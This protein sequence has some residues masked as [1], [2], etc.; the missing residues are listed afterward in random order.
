[1]A[2][3][4]FGEHFPPSSGN[5]FVSVGD[6]LDASCRFGLPHFQRGH[7]WH[8]D[9]VSRL[10][11]SLMWDTPCGSIIL[12]QPEGPIDDF[13]EPVREWGTN[14]LEYLVVDGQ[15]R[16]TALRDA[17]RSPVP[18]AVNLAAVPQFRALADGQ[19]PRRLRSRPLFV[20][21]PAVPVRVAPAPEVSPARQRAY[22]A[23]VRD[24]VR[25]TA[26]DE[27]GTSAWPEHYAH[28]R[29][30]GVGENLWRRMVDGLRAIPN[31][32]MQVVVKQGTSLSEIVQLYN[33]INSSGVAVRAE[34]R[35]FAAMVG[36]EPGAAAWLRECFASAHGYSA[37][38]AAQVDHNALLKRERERRFGFPLFVRTYAQAA[39]HHMD[40]DTSDL[41]YIS[42]LAWED[43]W[44]RAPQARADILDDSRVAI[45]RVANVVGRRLGCD[46]FRFVPAAEPLRPAF[47]LVLKYPDVDDPT[48]AGAVLRLQLGPLGGGPTDPPTRTRDIRSSNTLGEAVSALPTLPSRE[49]LLAS[50]TAC[51]SMQS[52]W[53]SVLYW[54]ERSRGAHDYGV[55]HDAA[56]RAAAAPHKEHIV[57]FSL[58]HPIF[59]DLD[60]TGHAK[61]HEANA[62]GNLT[63]ISEEFNF[64][65]G[66][67]PVDLDLAGVERL[68]P[69][70]LHTP[71]ILCAY[72]NAIAVLQSV[73]DLDA[74]RAAYRTF[75]ALRTQSLTD[76]LHQWMTQQGQV[77]PVE[78][79]L[80]PLPQ[81]I[82]PSRADLIRAH[83]WPRA[84]QN[85]VLELTRGMDV[86]A[87]NWMTLLRCGTG[88]QRTQVAYKLRL[89]ND[90]C[91]IAVGTRIPQAEELAASLTSH[92]PDSDDDS[93]QWW[94]HLDPSTPESVDAL[95][96]LARYLHAA[97]D[98]L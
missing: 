96:E 44:M 79:G 45:A 41:D 95:G 21:V 65:H 6:L 11:E 60:A 82:R 69:H 98:G 50:L 25:L 73:E 85:A 13:G 87:G 36:F 80:R 5:G 37:A 16:L 81:R 17:L 67:D 30:S 40:L 53:V 57:P 48:L 78:P 27:S 33:R 10:L 76:G 9:S 2:N 52:P 43:A 61:T 70:H 63:F 26:I 77:E 3:G 18:W 59:D 8:R 49:R 7:V 46:D 92:I 74:A 12:W 51:R 38:A 97:R 31:R 28:W 62:V 56:L 4:R 64:D 22:D 54:Y 32:H 93:S 84:F 94:F 68:R 91:L 86:T 66:A 89:R 19:P 23:D 35:A 47:A 72:R 24:L 39:G 14:G 34:E 83:P 15:Q 90:G 88:R 1:M 58:L 20:P 42:G 55:D 71:E 29:R 75:V